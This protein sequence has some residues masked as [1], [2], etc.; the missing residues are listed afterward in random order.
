MPP[1]SLGRTIG[2]W[3]A[4]EHISAQGLAQASV[5][6]GRSSNHA[7]DGDDERLPPGC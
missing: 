2:E 7:G 3:F 1:G 6:R 4:R 5:P